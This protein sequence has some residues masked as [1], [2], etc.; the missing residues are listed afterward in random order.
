MLYI[1]L[2]VACM[3]FN[4]NWTHGSHCVVFCCALLCF[5]VFW[6]MFVPTSFRVTL[7]ALEQP[8]PDNKVHGANMGPTWGRQDPGGPHVGPMDLAIGVWL[9]RCHRVNES[10]ESTNKAKYNEIM[11]IPYGIWRI[12]NHI[13]IFSSFLVSLLWVYNGRLPKHCPE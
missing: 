5:V 6:Y 4:D 9:H 12:K 10:Y 7:M 11:C 1:Y 13:L 3:I 2:N 8:Y